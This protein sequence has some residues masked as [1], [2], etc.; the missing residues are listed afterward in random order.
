MQDC[1]C[2][3]A[4]SKTIQD[5]YQFHLFQLYTHEPVKQL[6]LNGVGYPFMKQGNQDCTLYSKYPVFNSPKHIQMNTYFLAI[7]NTF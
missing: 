5:W 7:E 3:T 6:F 1:L 2:G 4:S